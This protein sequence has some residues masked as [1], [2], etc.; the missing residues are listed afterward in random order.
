M[1]LRAFDDRSGVHWE[2]WEAHPT[3]MERRILTDRRSVVRGEETRRLNGSPPSGAHGDGWLVF[4]SEN[5][6]RRQR[7]IPPAWDKLADAELVSLLTQ[8]RPSGPRSRVIE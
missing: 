2:V 5:Q 7:P 8:S 4:R 1:P 3:L 6:R